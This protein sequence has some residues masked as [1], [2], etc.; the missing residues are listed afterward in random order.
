MIID[1]LLANMLFKVHILHSM[2]GRVRLHI[3]QATK[4]PKEWQLEEI[5][6]EVAKNIRGV[7]NIRF[8]YITGNALVEY[9]PE[10]T[11]EKEVLKTLNG[12]AR[13]AVRHL[14]QLK[15]FG[16]DKKDKVL[17]YLTR[18]WQPLFDET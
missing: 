7:K 10:I 8:T 2:P 5:Y 4:I 14:D 15:R 18:I 3:P 16:P 11:S 17:A 13:M 6:F 12:M 1:G 9:D